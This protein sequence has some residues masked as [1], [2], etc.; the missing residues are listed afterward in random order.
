[1]VVRIGE[2]Q[3]GQVTMLAGSAEAVVEQLLGFTKLGFTA[4]N[5]VPTGLDR[6]EQIERLGR[7]V[8]PELR[9]AV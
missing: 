1:M 8:L 3:P 6:M 2:E 7:D 4:F 5:L 9:R